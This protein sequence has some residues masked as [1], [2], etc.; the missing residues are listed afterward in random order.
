MRM[1][2]EMH[3]TLSQ[4]FAGIGFQLKAIREGM[5]DGLPRLHQQLD[6]A[7]ELVR[8]SHQETLRS[9]AVLRPIQPG[10]EGLVEALREC[11]TRLVE[12]GSVEVIASC[13]GEAGRT[14]LRVVDTLYHVGQ[15]AL[16][17]AVRHG[18]PERLQIQLT[19][20]KGLCA[21]AYRG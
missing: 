18:Q 20:E 6:L 8:H 17:N 5:P 11:A 2:H 14:P 1:A 12:G 4:S 13:S 10:S 3:D 19:Y 21:A 16:A 15:E 7:S 9:I